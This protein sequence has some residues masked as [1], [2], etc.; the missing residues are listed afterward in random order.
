MALRGYFHLDLIGQG[1]FGDVWRARHLLTNQIVAVKVIALDGAD[2]DAVSRV[3]K[4]VAICS[5]M[6][7]PLIAHFFECR[8][9]VDRFYIVQECA[10]GGSFLNFVNRHNRLTEA[11]CRFYFHQ[12]LSVVGYLHSMRVVHRDLKMEN[13]LLDCNNNIRLVDFGLSEQLSAD[14]EVLTQPCGTPAYAAPEVISGGGYGCKVDVWGLGVLLYAMAVGRLP[15]YDDDLSTLLH[16]IVHDDVEIPPSLSAPLRDLIARLLQKAPERRIELAS[17]CDHEWVKSGAAKQIEGLKMVGM[18][19]REVV[20]I[21]QA[22]LEMD[23][24]NL[25]CDLASGARNEATT[26]YMILRRREMTNELS[27]LQHPDQMFVGSV[28]SVASSG[29][30]VRLGALAPLPRRMMGSLEA[31]AKGAFGLR[32]LAGAAVGPD[33]LEQVRLAAP[34]VFASSPPMHFELSIRGGIRA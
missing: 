33:R 31:F 34:D 4:E 28:P 20:Q 14:D 2:P 22:D 6:D 17:V 16:Q 18:L 9:T 23:V 11:Q 10:Q 12:L 3:R 1:S 24:S 15:F 19:D 21:M 32:S 26:V 7:H 13:L 29:H 5:K 30:I 25:A 27:G 8:S